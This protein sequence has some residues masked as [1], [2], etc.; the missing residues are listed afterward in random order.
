MTIRELAMN[1]IE[2]ADT[3]P[4]EEI[5]LDLA[6]T[7]VESMDNDDDDLPEGLTP[8]SFMAAWN[9]IIREGANYADL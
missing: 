2:N 5:D 8:E 1:W 9:D 3:C 4:V 6:T 7:Y